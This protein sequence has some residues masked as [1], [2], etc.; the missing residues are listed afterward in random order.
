MNNFI[1]TLLS[2]EWLSNNIG[3]IFNKLGTLLIIFTILLII[4]AICSVTKN[5]LVILFK[6][7]TVIILAIWAILSIWT[8]VFIFVCPLFYFTA[9]VKEFL[10]LQ[11]KLSNT[12]L[13]NVTLLLLFSYIYGI[14][15]KF[16]GENFLSLI[17]ED[18]ED[19][20]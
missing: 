5:P 3:D 7:L 11:Y 20:G 8:V 17:A 9:W 12:L 13:M 18:K 19:K 14:I 16:I 6:V 2:T 10:I 1:Y 4:V 15:I